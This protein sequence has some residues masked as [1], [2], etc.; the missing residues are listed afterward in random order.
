MVCLYVHKPRE[1]DAEEDLDLV[2]KHTFSY[3]RL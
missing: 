1:P 2:A 3:Y